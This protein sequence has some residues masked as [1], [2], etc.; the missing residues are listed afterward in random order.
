[1]ASQP[2]PTRSI[3]AKRVSDAALRKLIAESK[4]KYGAAIKALATNH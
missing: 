4:R 2:A 3:K 1:M